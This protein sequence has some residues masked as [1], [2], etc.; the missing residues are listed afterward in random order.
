MFSHSAAAT[1]NSLQSCLTLCDPIDGSPP[2][3][4]IPGILQARTVEWVAISFSN[5][6]KWKVKVKSLSRVRLLVT[7]WTAA[8]QAPPFLGYSRQEYWSGVPLPSPYCCSVTQWCPTLCYPMGWSTPGLPVPPYLSEFAQIHVHCISDSVQPSHPLM[9]F[10][11]WPLSFP[12]SWS[13]VMN[14]PFS[15]DDQ[16]TG[17][18]ASTSVLPV[19]IQ[20][21]SPLRS[22]GLISLLSK[23]LS[24]VFSSTTVWRAQFF[25]VLPSLQFSSPMEDQGKM[26]EQQIIDTR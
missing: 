11:F 14:H 19:N 10:P 9:P 24:E 16:N 23:G 22:I 21:W 17:A 5:A 4:T 20:R 8:Y 15:S 12:A 3:S 26:K 13:F 25:G 2:G 6:W 7:P 18:S 1:A